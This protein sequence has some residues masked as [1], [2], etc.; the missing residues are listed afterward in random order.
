[1]RALASL[2]PAVWSATTIS[3]RL[4]EVPASRRT[5]MMAAAASVANTSR[6]AWLRAAEG[7]TSAL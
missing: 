7:V 3:R 1:V 4:I 6:N 5:R 2:T